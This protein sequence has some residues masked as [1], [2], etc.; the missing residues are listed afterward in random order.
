MTTD[1]K[2]EIKGRLLLDFQE[3]EDELA[4]LSEKARKEA[5]NLR[6]LAGF[7]DSVRPPESKTAYVEKDPQY[8]AARFATICR[9]CGYGEALDLKAFLQLANELE[10]SKLRVHVLMK[11]KTDLGLR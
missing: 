4:H 2:R 10:Q 7:I 3:A 6:T 8:H 5:A 11:Q 1:E 9:N